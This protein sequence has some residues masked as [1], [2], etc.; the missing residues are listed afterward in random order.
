M[1]STS[2]VEKSPY[3]CSFLEKLNLT[4]GNLSKENQKDVHKFLTT[5]I[6]TE[7]PSIIVKNWKGSNV[8]NR[9]GLK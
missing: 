2:Q 4:F 3:H 6:H 5:R 7:L 9:I 8:Q 1:F